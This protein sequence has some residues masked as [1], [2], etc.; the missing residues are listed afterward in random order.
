MVSVKAPQRHVTRSGLALQV[1]AA[2]DYDE[3]EVKAFFERVS[4]DDR[5]FRFQRSVA[6]LD[7][8]Q[9]VPIVHVDHDLN[10]TY[11]GFEMTEGQL[12]AIAQF[13]TDAAREEAE[14]AVT[15]RQDFKG[16]GIGW[17]MLDLLAEEAARRGVRRVV[18]IED[19][20]NHA[21]IGLEREM[22]FVATVLEDDP[23]RVILTR[24]LV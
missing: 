20:A 10:E 3:R 23:A 7:H 18:S 9:L 15:V 19:R 6:H 12:V 11:L 1:R 14:V 2:T 5:R 4:D 21:A 8:D 17:M 24:Q 16:Q 22:G 13:A